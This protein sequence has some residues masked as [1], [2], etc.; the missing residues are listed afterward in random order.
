MLWS[1]VPS[2]VGDLG[3]AVD[4]EYLAAVRFG[5]V[6]AESGQLAASPSTDGES[7]LLAE[8]GR[9]LD[10]YLAGRLLVFDLPTLVRHGSTFER[11]V[12]DAISAVPHG[13]TMTYGDIARDLGD[14]GAARAVGVACNRNPL[15]LVVPCHRVVGAGGRLVGFGGGLE[16]KRILLDLE[17]RLRLARDFGVVP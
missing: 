1:S 11:G 10:A 5:G 8:V 15:P 2:P 7:W 14:V 12:W 6:P 16:R 13:E 9:Q 3:V 4:G 17:A